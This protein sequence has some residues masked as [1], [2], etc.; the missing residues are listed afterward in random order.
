MERLVEGLVALAG[1]FRGEYWLEVFL[2]ADVT[3]NDAEVSRLVARVDRI[4]PTRVQLNTVARPPAESYALAVSRDRMHELAGRFHPPADVI[5][6]FRAEAERPEV[7]AN[8]DRILEL[9]RRRPS[10]LDDVAAGLGMHP[11]EVVKYTEQLT[12]EGLLL[13][14]RSGGR[15]YYRLP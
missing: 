3:A 8:R 1:E 11:N 15:V 12:A 10:T 6:E 9:L 2:L 14:T 7:T 4:R 5:C 13:R